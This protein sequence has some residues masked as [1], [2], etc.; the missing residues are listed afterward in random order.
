MAVKS[1]LYF[2]V[3]TDTIMIQMSALQQ[4]TEQLSGL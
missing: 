4:I 1:T 2:F 3:H